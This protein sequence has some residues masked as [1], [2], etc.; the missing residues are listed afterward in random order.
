MSL[1]PSCQ[2]RVNGVGSSPSDDI[3]QRSNEAKPPHLPIGDDVET[4]RHLEL[5][6]IVDRTIL[7]LLELGGRYL[8]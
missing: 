1:L 4:G 3:T 8:F 6:C 7:D 5:N 2:G